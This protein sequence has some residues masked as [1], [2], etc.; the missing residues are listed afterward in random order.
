MKKV[1][2]ALAELQK[3]SNFQVWN[4]LILQLVFITMCFGFWGW[5]VGLTSIFGMLAINNRIGCESKRQ[6][7]HLAIIADDLSKRIDKTNVEN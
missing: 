3:Q 2:P 6:I 5:K 7:I 1:D 4:L